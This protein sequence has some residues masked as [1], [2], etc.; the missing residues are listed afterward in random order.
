MLLGKLRQ[1]WEKGRSWKTDELNNWHEGTQI[2]NLPASRPMG[3]PPKERGS[4][5]RIFWWETGQFP[6]L[7][8]SFI[9]ESCGENP[10]EWKR[11]A[12][13][14]VIDAAFEYDESRTG[15]WAA[16]GVGVAFVN[17]LYFS[18]KTQA[19]RIQK[20]PM[21]TREAQCDLHRWLCLR[22]GCTRV[23]NQ[24]FLGKDHI[25]FWA[26]TCALSESS[27]P[28][29]ANWGCAISVLRHA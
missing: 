24:M 17:K 12:F 18:E 8:A 13:A 20:P 21:K 15:L 5:K 26:K 1:V 7:S 11:R 9:E 14:D 6:W 27:N 23:C 3:K 16:C 19:Q 28:S 29:V 10:M 2:N 4:L 25:W 22:T